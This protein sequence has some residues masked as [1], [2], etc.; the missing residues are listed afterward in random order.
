MLEPWELILH[1]TY[2]GV[3]GV[4]FDQSPNRSSHGVAVNLGPGAFHADGAT[5]G[6]GAV[7][8][9]HD[10]YI[11]VPTS[12]DV[13]APLG[14]IRVEITCRCETVDGGGTLIDGGSFAFAVSQGFF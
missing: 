3:P 2:S 14:G 6:S 4:I 8:F 12:T 13:W 10:G 7:T 9:G 5:S 11:Q 1:H